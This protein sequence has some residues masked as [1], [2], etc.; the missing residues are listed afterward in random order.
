MNTLPA[1]YTTNEDTPVKLSG[2]SV[3]D[4][5]AGA[6]NVTVTLSV[7]S[8]TLTAANAGSVTVSGSGT[9]SIVLTG[10]VANIDAY[11][12]NASNQ[13]SYVPVANANGAVA[14]TMT[15]SDLGNTGSGGTL[16]DTD[17]ININITAVNDAP[18]L[19]F[20]P[21]YATFDGN[22][23]LSGPVATTE[24]GNSPG[25]GVTLAGWVNWDGTGSTGVGQQFFYNGSTSD[26]G[27]GVYGAP[28]VGGLHLQI[29]VGGVTGFD[30]GI[31]LSPGWHNVAVSHDNSNFT[32]FVDG[33]AVATFNSIAAQRHPG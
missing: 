11:L 25:H 2:L 17:I 10:S 29:L 1:S 23:A 15:T 27:F 28:G 4:V 22:D 21:T 32:L 7:A 30:T 14:L 16:T 9:G 5:D 13:P 31:T 24:I 20:N 8:G 18:A 6:A 3:A 19:A 12:G 26:S 33:T